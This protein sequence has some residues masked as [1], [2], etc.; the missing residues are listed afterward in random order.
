MPDEAC[1]APGEFTDFLGGVHVHVEAVQRQTRT[2]RTV[3]DDTIDQAVEKVS[4]RTR[5]TLFTF[6]ATLLS[7]RSDDEYR[8]DASS[9]GCSPW[10]RRASAEELFEDL[11]RASP[12]F[13]PRGLR[14]G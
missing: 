8:S 11:C 13:S 4:T 10:H 14:W 12:G 1:R 6:T 3:L 9:G 5:S 2:I 7:E